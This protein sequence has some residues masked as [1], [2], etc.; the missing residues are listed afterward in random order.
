MNAD[1][2]SAS[3]LD[4]KL[5]FGRYPTQ[6]EVELLEQQGY[7]CFVDLTTWDEGLVAYATASDTIVCRSPI[8]DQRVPATP[9]ELSRFAEALALV[10]GVLAAREVS[11]YVHCRGGHGRSALFAACALLEQQML[12]RSERDAQPTDLAALVLARVRAAHQARRV[13]KP[14][15]RR[16]GAP[17]T[18]AQKLFVHQHALQVAAAKR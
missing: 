5:R 3:L 4:G 8:V 14:R 18:A 15:W 7:G 17:Q 1:D 9:D 10:H 16:Q 12:W 11:V 2:F 13:M 6:N